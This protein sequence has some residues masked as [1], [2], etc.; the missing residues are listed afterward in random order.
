MSLGNKVRDDLIV[1]QR[2]LHLLAERRQTKAMEEK[3]RRPDVVL[4][5]VID[6]GIER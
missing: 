5:E 6:R 1:S 3:G 4:G 2:V